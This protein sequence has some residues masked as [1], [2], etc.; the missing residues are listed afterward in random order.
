MVSAYGMAIQLHAGPPAAGIT[1]VCSLLLCCVV[2]CCAAQC[3][4]LQLSMQAHVVAQ[5]PA[6]HNHDM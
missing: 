6:K 1:S 5:L 2:L 3:S 4:V